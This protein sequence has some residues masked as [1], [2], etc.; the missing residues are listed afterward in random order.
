MFLSKPLVFHICSDF[1]RIEKVR[2]SIGKITQGDSE[3]HSNILKLDSIVKNMI[4]R[5]NKNRSV[6]GERFLPGF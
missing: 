3:P 2:Q 4:K 6:S 5:S 1:A